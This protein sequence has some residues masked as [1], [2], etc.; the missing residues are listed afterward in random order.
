MFQNAVDMN[1]FAS[2][3]QRY[4]ELQ[5]LFNG[6]YDRTGPAARHSAVY[7]RQGIESLFEQ[8]P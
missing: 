8:F 5:F 6:P 3:G 7:Y 4:V 2:E 1:H